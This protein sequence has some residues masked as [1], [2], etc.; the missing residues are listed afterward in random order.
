VTNPLE[1]TLTREA[2]SN[3]PPPV[4]LGYQQRWVADQSP[5]KLAEKSR[6][7][8]LT[9]A[10]A[11]DDA[12]IA[13][14]ADGS[15]V[16]Y[17]SATEDMAIEYIEACAMWARAYDLV[18][19]Q[20][21]EG[22]F[23]DTDAGGDKQIK[24]YKIAFPKSGRRIVALSSRPANLRGKQG[25]VVIDEAAFAPDLAGLI[26]AAMAMLMW[27]D[28]VRIISTHNGDDNP[29][30]E[31]ITEI[32]AGKRKGAV[33][34]ISFADAV[35]D[36]LFRRVCLR[37]GAPWTPAAEAAWVA[38]VRSFY[39]DDADEEL[40]V[41]PARGGG[42]Y[43]PLALIE[44]RMVSVGGYV[45]LVR[46]RWPAM[47][48]LLPEPTRAN[49]VAEFC[50]D[51]L[52]AI[53]RMLDADRRHGFGEDFARE[54]D[55]TVIT[56]LE[57][58]KDLVIRPRLVVELG[59]CP[60]AQQRQ[61]LKYVV[62]ALPRFASAALDAGGNGAELAEFAADQW[63]HSRIE[64]IKLSD[65]FYLEQMPRFK[66]ALED[67]TLD[68]LPRDDQCRDDLRAIK[69]H[70]GVP[71]LGKAKTQTADGKKVQRHGDFAISLFLGHYAMRREVAPIEFMSAAGEV[72]H[73]PDLDFTGY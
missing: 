53:L 20:I 45:P 26:K 40:D 27:G 47:F 1:S 15:N 22:I 67:A 4:L 56:V 68:A 46:E 35:V 42:T 52:H 44:A 17:I 6:R 63:G 43:L 48:S 66:A 55:L 50:R 70:G 12:L 8:G 33:H 37:K 62:G 58:G 65:K 64:Q 24:T 72:D 73:R 54:G 18:A 61:I 3:A 29:F 30:N 13:A 28:K 11:A 39:G 59:G 60:F 19:G 34:R 16:F 69:K 36:G 25:V 2:A 38:D 57:E 71:K 14:G 32:R 41:V 9:W 51:R 23:H 21:E 49:E 31:L 10:E 5:L 7:I